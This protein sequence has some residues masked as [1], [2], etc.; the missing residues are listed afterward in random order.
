MIHA[1]QDRGA[2]TLPML[3][4]HVAPVERAQGRATRHYHYPEN[5]SRSERRAMRKAYMIEFLANAGAATCAEVAA[6]F[7]VISEAAYKD[8]MQ[9]KA[10]GLVAMVRGARPMRYEVVE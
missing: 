9:L 2:I 8:L 3:F 4:G 1:S 10:E 5:A 6:E 7:G